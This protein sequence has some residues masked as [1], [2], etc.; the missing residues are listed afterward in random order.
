MFFILAIILI[1]SRIS[2]VNSFN[3]AQCELTLDQ[4]R[5]IIGLVSNW[6]FAQNDA[7]INSESQDEFN[8]NVEKIFDCSS[9]LDICIGA[10]LNCKFGRYTSCNAL[11]KSYYQD[12]IKTLK[13]IQFGQVC[14]IYHIILF[15][16]MIYDILFD[17]FNVY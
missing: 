8:E 17:I 16:Y 13:G 9:R 5:S 12:A 4:R 7:I 1:I 3:E 14:I 11:R 15:L 2:F 6:Y 10:D